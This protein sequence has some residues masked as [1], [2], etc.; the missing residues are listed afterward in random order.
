MPG[1]EQAAEKSTAAQ[2]KSFF[3]VWNMVIIVMFR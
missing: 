1:F 3:I 2:S